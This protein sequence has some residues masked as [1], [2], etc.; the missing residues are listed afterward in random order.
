MFNVK[1]KNVPFLFQSKI[2][3][4][5]SKQTNNKAYKHFFIIF[6][7]SGKPNQQ[8]LPFVTKPNTD[9]LTVFDRIFLQ[10]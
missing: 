7:F 6:T 5:E 9:C 4:Y 10:I 1:L 8:R 3:S 2:C